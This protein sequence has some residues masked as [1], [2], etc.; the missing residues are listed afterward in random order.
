MG[1]ELETIVLDWFARAIGLPKPFQSDESKFVGGGCFQASASD[2]TLVA[3]LAAR[4]RAIE[5][6]RDGAGEEIHDSAYLSELVVYSSKEA[7]SSVEKACKMALIR[8]RTLETDEFGNMTGKTVADAIRQDV[9]QG[10]TPCMV[11]VTLGTTGLVSYDKLKDIAKVVRG[12]NVKVPIWIHVDAAYSGSTFICPEYRHSMEGVEEADSFM[13]NPNKLMLGA[14]DM[15]CFFVKDVKTFGKSLVINPTYLEN[16]YTHERQ[17]DYRHMS[18]ALSRRFRSL[19]LFFLMR[20]YGISGLQNYVRNI[21]QNAIYFLE[22]VKKDPRFEVFEPM[23]VGLIGFRYR[24]APGADPTPANDRTNYLINVLHH[25]HK[26]Y[27]VPTKFQGKL[28]LRFSV[29]YA[30][31]T[32]KEIGK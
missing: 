5:L 1:T 7:H 27:V 4:A 8:L 10:L 20:S 30:G 29:N 22:L 11:V 17:M 32:K 15:T 19:K 24:S 25:G 26:L 3:A 2:A 6:L 13:V 12:A 31:T 9:A 21:C 18:V 23:N 28:Y 14:F 16:N